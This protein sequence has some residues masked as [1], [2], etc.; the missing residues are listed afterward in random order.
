MMYIDINER[1]SM[2]KIM[3]TLLLSALSTGSF[4]YD[5]VEFSQAQVISDTPVDIRPNA[6]KPSSECGRAKSPESERTPFEVAQDRQE[7]KVRP[8]PNYPGHCVPH[9]LQRHEA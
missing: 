4:A 3:F 9:V 5:S 7:G 8:I 2:K 6:Q 1:I